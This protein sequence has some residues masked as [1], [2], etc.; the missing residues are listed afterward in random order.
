MAFDDLREFVAHLEK[1]GHL[2]RVRARVLSLLDEE[3]E[4]P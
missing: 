2:K 1:T 4:R 3:L